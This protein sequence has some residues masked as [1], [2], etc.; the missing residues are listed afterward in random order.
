ME[1]NTRTNLS[2]LGCCLVALVLNVAASPLLAQRGGGKI[3]GTVADSTGAVL[4]RVEVTI[5]EVNTAQ[6]RLAITGDAGRYSAAQ[7]AT[8]DYEIRA[9]L[10]GFQAGVRQGIRLL[11]GQEAVV[12]FS[13]ELGSI[14]EEV[15][16]TGQAPL[17]NTTSST[18]SSVINEN[19]VHDLPLNSRNITQLAL[20]TPGVVQLR[21][22]VTG[23]V[24]LGAPSVRISIAGA[25]FYSTGFLL[26]GTDVTDS[27]RGM[28]PGG[29]AAAMFGVETLKEMQVITNN[30]SAEYGRF[31]GGLMGIVT[32]SALI[33]IW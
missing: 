13:L 32:L 14:S 7:L 17:V 24:T 15:V 19:Q 11:I 6:S 1:R 16:V 28:G 26:D 29:A 23:G 4:P 20:L 27:S 10:A 2:L 30:Y 33:S 8:G 3:E 12:D 31:S 9:E 21:T 5:T 22:G 25:K 18:L